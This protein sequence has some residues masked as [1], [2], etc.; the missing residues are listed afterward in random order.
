MLYISIAVELG[1]SVSFCVSIGVALLHDK[2]DSHMIK[3]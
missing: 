2:L 1:I 3:N